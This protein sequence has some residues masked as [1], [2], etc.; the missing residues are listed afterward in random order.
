MP[1]GWVAVGQIAKAANFPREIAARLARSLKKQH[2]GVL[3]PV[4]SER[5]RDAQVEPGHLVG[6][7]IELAALAA[8]GAIE[9]PETV[10]RFLGFR[11]QRV[12]LTAEG[13]IGPVQI[14]VTQSEAAPI[15]DIVLPGLGETLEQMVDRFAGPL[16]D[17]LR[18]DIAATLSIELR[19]GQDEVASVN[20][21]ERGIGTFQ[22]RYAADKPP[23]PF[24][25]EAAMLRSVTIPGGLLLELGAIWA[26][27]KTRIA[28]AA[29][30]QSVSRTVFASRPRLGDS[31][32]AS[33][34]QLT[35]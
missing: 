13:A 5:V 22:C 2:P 31:T 18:A 26:N 24:I 12:M 20:F 11:R 27:S 6:L 32:Q 30:M 17:Q 14:D 7:T 25:P 3:W 1:R 28:A 15:G 4:A 35:P 33:Q 10:R 34:A 29:R 21:G 9:A 19:L 23:A 16:P 8:G